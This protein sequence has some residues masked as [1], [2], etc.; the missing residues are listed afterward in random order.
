MLN[1]NARFTALRRWIQTPRARRA[2]TIAG[3]GAAGAAAAGAG[4]A[5]GLRGVKE[6][7][8]ADERVDLWHATTFDIGGPAD[9]RALASRLARETLPA[10]GVSLAEFQDAAR[11]LEPVELELE[12]LAER[13]V[14]SST[15][16]ANK[17]D[18]D[19]AALVA[20]WREQGRFGSRQTGGFFGR[21]LTSDAQGVD[22]GATVPPYLVRDQDTLAVS[23]SASGNAKE[24]EA[25]VVALQRWGCARL[26][27]AVTTEDVTILR[28]QLGL[29]SVAGASTN[30]SSARQHPRRAGEVGQWILQKDPNIAM[31]RYTFGRLHCLLRGSPFLE[32]RATSVHSAVAPLVH[33]FFRSDV[34]KG[35][36]VFLSE[37]QLIIADPCAESQDWHL[38]ATAGPGLTVLV[39]LSNVMHDRASQALLPGTHHLH[40]PHASVRERFGRCFSALCSSHG[41]VTAPPNVSESASEKATKLNSPGLWAAGDALVLDGRVLHRGL[42]ND[43]LGAPMPLL[44]LRYD[45]KETPPPGCGRLRLLFMARVGTLL[46]AVFRLYAAV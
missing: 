35:G 18:E 22:I 8:H 33:A 19:V 31:G 44:I 32:A 38:D 2:F 16:S 25:A 13:H 12:E 29:V 7:L 37:A 6:S 4:L 39:P 26:R 24:R 14:E 3:R 10:I 42:I 43:G 30:S 5:F 20:R 41:A 46:D 9:S 1:R 45:L 11:R 15:S 36:R 40:D 34:A 23:A 21:R 27:G 17:L 28:E